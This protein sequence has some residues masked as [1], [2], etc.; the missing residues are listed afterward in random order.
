MTP[1]T[2]R[3]PM[4]AAGEWAPPLSFEEYAR[5]FLT[6]RRYSTEWQATLRWCRERLVPGLPRKSP[7]AV[8]SVGAGNGDF[9]RRLVPLLHS[10]F[11]NLEYVMLEPNEALCRQLRDYI[12]GQAGDGVRFDLKPR[13]FEDCAICRA[14]D[15]V[16]FTHC[17]Y[18]IPDR[19]AAV[20]QALR[21]I[22]PDGLVLIIHQTQ[23][24]ID[25]VQQ[26][27]LRLVK[28]SDQE[29][30]C[31]RDLQDILERRHTPYRLEVLPSHID[32]SECFRPG[33]ADGE[34]LLSF[35]LESDLRLLDPALKQEIVEYLDELS[36]FS[37]GRRLLYHPVA[38]FCL[39]PAPE[40]G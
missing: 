29:M 15:L 11:P 10:R 1:I 20:N 35:F 19:Q 36:Y 30:F 21:S 22:G 4:T 31:S 28:G 3:T 14:F 6:F 8:L 39:A 18:Y 9:D 24:G 5:C 12:A 37:E 17:L 26:R 25:Q 13:S 38:V 34:A 23:W 16:H 27:F 2:P 7:F 32:V 40:E 33:S